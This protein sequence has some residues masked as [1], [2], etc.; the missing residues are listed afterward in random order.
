MP[1]L[2]ELT[3][4]VSTSSKLGYPLLTFLVFLP[5]IG[6]VV[7]MLMPSRRPELRARRRLRHEH[8]HL[9]DGAVPAHAVRRRP[10]QARLPARSRTT[11]GSARSACAGRS[12]STASACSWSR[13]SALLFPIGLLAS[14]KVAEAEGVHR[15]DAAARVGDDRRVPRARRAGVLH[16]LRVRARADV[17]PHRGLGSRQPALRGDEVLPV[18]DGRLRVLVRRDPVGRVHAPALD[19]RAD[20]RRAHPHRLGGR[21]HPRRHR[22]GA[23]PRVRGRLRGEG[24]AVPVPHVAARRAHRRADRGLGRAGRRDAEDRRVRLLALRDPVLP[25]G[26]GRPRAAPASCSP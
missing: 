3:P 18:H 7:A 17:L 22:E 5:A 15:L 25:A 10:A 23:V 9:R 6:A 20:L 4:I 16:L 19:A 8:G 11:P 14:A 21:A 2:A 24:A 26:R 1:L 12:A 13:S